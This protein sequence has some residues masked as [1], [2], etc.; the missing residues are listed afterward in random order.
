MEDTVIASLQAEVDKK[1]FLCNTVWEL[2]VTLEEKKI[3]ALD[4]NFIVEMRKKTKT[5]YS[6]C[7]D[8]LMYS[9]RVVVPLSLEKQILK[10]FHTGHPDI[11]PE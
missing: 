11:Y 3:K 7:N 4:D 5:E 6:I 8:V 9:K 10:E 2:P 1:N